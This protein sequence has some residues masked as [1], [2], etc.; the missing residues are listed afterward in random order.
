MR[1]E[2]PAATCTIF[3]FKDGFLSRI[4][5]DLRIR[6][7][8]FWIEIEGDRIRAEFDARSL[9]V[10]TAMKDGRPHDALGPADKEK[11]RATIAGEVLHTSRHPTVSFESDSFDAE[12]VRGTLKLHGAS[13]PLSFRVERAGVQ[14]KIRVTI[15]QPDY[16]IEPYRAA[17]GALKLKPDVIVELTLPG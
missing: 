2:P 3:T 15:H 9:E 14:R 16:G 7:K 1:L 17:L 12:S 8:S 5:H 11:I 4:A 13:R 10:E 6:V